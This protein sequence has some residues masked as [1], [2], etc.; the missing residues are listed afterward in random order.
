MMLRSCGNGSI[1]YYMDSISYRYRQ[2]DSSQLVDLSDR[3]FPSSYVVGLC[4]RASAVA[5][6]NPQ[7]AEESRG[8][9][10]FFLPMN[11]P[12]SLDVW[13]KQKQLRSNISHL[14][15]AMAPANKQLLAYER[16]AVE[17]VPYLRTLVTD[18]V[19][20]RIMPLRIRMCMQSIVFNTSYGC[21]SDSRN[22]VDSVENNASASI[23]EVDDISSFSDSD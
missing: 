13:Q 2:F 3:V 4:G 9:R 21:E 22:N 12:K 17:I 10:E 18:V 19:Y 20:N 11:R 7:Y 23:L 1:M 6:H 8:K 14:R 5:M 15:D 16:V